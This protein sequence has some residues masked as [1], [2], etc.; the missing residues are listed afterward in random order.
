MQPTPSTPRLAA[1][2]PRLRAWTL[3]LHASLFIVLLALGACRDPKV[4]AYRVPKEAAAELPASKPI[5]APSALPTAASADAVHAAAN[6]APGMDPMSPAPTAPDTHALQTASGPGLSWTAPGTWQAKPATMMRKATFV[7]TNEAGATA[8]LAVSAFPGDVGGDVANVN[9]W[10]GQVGLDPVDDAAAA[11]AIERL[12]VN[13]LKIG[14]VDLGT[15]SSAEAPHLL[16]AM[17]PYEGAT[18]FFKLVGPAVAVTPHKAE[19][20]AFIKT[21]KPAAAPTP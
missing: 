7:L 4:T 21:I 10:R 17:V 12:E 1:A 18:W 19:F 20:V 14:L 16:G 6:A 9:R 8:E 3:S 11:A 13:G 5:H 15:A 2:S